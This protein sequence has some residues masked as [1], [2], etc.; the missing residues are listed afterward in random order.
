MS[1][2]R[3]KWTQ[4]LILAT[5]AG[6][7]FMALSFLRTWGDLGSA[8]FG[9]RVIEST[10]AQPLWGTRLGLR[11]LG[12]V[13]A[14]VVVHLALG[15]A[16]WAL[17]HASRRAFPD[18]PNKLNAWIGFWALALISWV[19]TANAAW[20]PYSALGGPWHALATA[21]VGPIDVF[22]VFSVAVVAGV[23]YVLLRA[24]G[25][26]LSGIRRSRFVALG[27]TSVLLAAAVPLFGSGR[28]ASATPA[29]TPH[30]IVVGIDSL[31]ADYVRNDAIGLTPA[32]DEFLSQ[33]A[34][35]E[36]TITPL[37][38]TFP[39]WVSI[40]SGKHPHTTGA[41]INLYP[42][43]LITEGETLPG[44]LRE[45]GYRTRYA[46]DEVRFSNLDASYGFDTVTTPPMG[47]ADFLLGLVYDFPLSNL[48]VNTAAGRA[49][50][51]FAHANRAAAA[52]YD[53][54]AFVD[55]VADDLEFDEPTFL[56]VHLTLPHWPYH[57]ADAPGA[58]SSRELSI[59]QRYELAI[60]RVDRQFGDLM[61]M[62]EARG[63]LENAIVVVLSDHGESLGEIDELRAPEG[64]EGPEVFG[65]GTDVLAPEQ[66]QV[67]LS[68]RSYG[69]DFVK[70]ETTTLI[71]APASLEDIAPTIA[72]LLGAGHE[73]S[74][75]GWSLAPLLQ[76]G[77]ADTGWR[78][79]VR[80]IETEYAPPGFSVEDLPSVSEIQD[81]AQS[82]QVDPETDR[83]MI[84]PE[85][86]QQILQGRQ[87]AA[88][89]DGAMLASL[90]AAENREQFLIFVGDD[91]A[92]VQLSTAP[93]EGA[94]PAARS[95][96]NALYQRFATVR[97]RPVSPLAAFPG[98]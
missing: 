37:A 91:G 13:S 5:A 90:P 36:D 63:G 59:R 68:I 56:A 10:L 6:L 73:Q 25:P 14:L 77:T 69:N 58:G 9:G 67:L 51:P 93:G 62:I 60:E 94:P 74:F 16:A 75:E 49:L 89:R 48:L 43:D 87:F 98:P 19:F 24:A 32:I 45:A 88:M 34:I 42:R 47:S 2:H 8:I 1:P 80:F 57:W 27:V 65:H 28:G 46:I 39:A 11:L 54:D 44:L 52:T 83:L 66:Y 15:L 72:D 61:S 81:A 55:L 70:S 3:E 18:S 12:F 95:L 38:R 78:D 85:L 71:D 29:N 64:A 82:Y 41:I 50:F 23:G 97:E 76:S 7:V 21:G 26:R 40:V 84:R 92:A 4:G 35:F 22:G 31:R 30:V 86:L 53:P 96:W 17:G 20:F 79:R 33:A